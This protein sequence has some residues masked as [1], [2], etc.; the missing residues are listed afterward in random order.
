[1]FAVEIQILFLP[2]ACQALEGEKTSVKS[3]MEEATV[4]N[5]ELDS[6]LG[7][8]ETKCKLLHLVLN[9]KD[10]KAKL[11]EELKQMG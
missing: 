10:L 9:D 7:R 11:E 1:L 5:A 6:E 4:R 3:A 8:L 2:Q